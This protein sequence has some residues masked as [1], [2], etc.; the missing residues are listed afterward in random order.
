MR[1]H[2]VVCGFHRQINLLSK[3]DRE[4]IALLHGIDHLLI[5]RAVN[6][7]EHRVHPIEMGRCTMGDEELAATGVGAGVGHAQGTG[8]VAL[9]IR[10]TQFALDLVS[11][12]AGTGLASGTLFRIRATTLDHE[13]IDHAMESEVVV[14]PFLDEL[15]KVGDR[16]RCR[17]LEKGDVDIAARRGDRGFHG[18]RSSGALR[19]SKV[20][21]A[22]DLGSLGLTPER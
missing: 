14:E 1:E 19:L 6:A 4:P 9:R 7:T 18:P 10:C 12:S 21:G 2:P 17:L 16:G 20:E 22:D 15:D 3:R 11:R 8:R 5:S 13:I